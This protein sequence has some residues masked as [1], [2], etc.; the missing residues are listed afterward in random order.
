[1]LN[2]KGNHKKSVAATFQTLNVQFACIFSAY[3]KH[4]LFFINYSFLFSI[5]I[6]FLYNSSF[7]F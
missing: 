2:V 3:Q 4:Y 7:I 5:I 6:A 1:M